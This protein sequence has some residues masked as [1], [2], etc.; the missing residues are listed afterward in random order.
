MTQPLKIT[1]ELTPDPAVCNFHLEEP[2]SPDWTVTFGEPSASRGSA[3]AD[4]IFAVNGIV[5]IRVAGSTITVTKASEEPWPYVAPEIGKAI[6][7]AFASGKPLIAPE[8][9]A[10]L[11]GEPL[12]DIEGL[13]A[14][15][16]EEQ[17]NPA[18]ASHG[19]FV[20]LVKVDGRDVH[21]EMGG[22][23]QGCSASKATMK[24]GVESAIRRI[25]P[26]VRHIVDVTDHAAGVNPYFR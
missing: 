15:L 19:G 23:C 25:A 10:A 1:G 3:L 21:L 26:Q 7:S 9:F 24:Y 8:V 6:R 2:V 13:V 17:V 12:A 16:L 20:R 4:Q 5:S 14:E 11:E 22:G 18:L